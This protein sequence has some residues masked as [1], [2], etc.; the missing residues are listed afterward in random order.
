MFGILAL[1]LLMV[2]HE[3]GH[4]FA[5][6]LFGMRVLKFSIGFGPPFFQILP[7]DGYFWLTTAG[8]R[9]RLR[10][11][12]HK[13]ERQGE[14]VYQVAMIPFFAYVQIA[15]MNPLEELD[16]NDKSNFSNASLWAR[17]V[18]IFGGPLS[19]YLCASV[20]FFF[21]L[22]HGGKPGVVMVNNEPE[23]AAYVSPLPDR[24]AAKAGILA[25][26]KVVEVAGTSVGTWEQMAAQ[27]S[28]RPG[29]TIKVVVE[30]DS[31][32]TSIELVP[33]N[34]NGK[35]RIGVAPHKLRVPFGEAAVSSLTEPT[36]VVQ[37]VFLGLRELFRGKTEGLGGPLRMISETSEA[38]RQGLAEYL[39]LLGILS[40][41]IGVFNL[42]PF[43][44][45]DGGR[46]AFLGY[47]AITRRKPNAKVEIYTNV[48]GF[49]TLSGLALYVT[50]F[51][52]L[53]HM[54]S[55]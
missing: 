19:N 23:L 41:Y 17:I 15:G 30:R 6:R 54:L 45:L 55:K 52:D 35:G 31:V 21:A 28:K 14:T 47:E 3:S 11:W 4:F 48:F 37:G 10:L 20:F 34:D 44:A 22:L 39:Y 49:V 12:R 43:P 51:K 33:A 24:P 16:P 38:A 40:A 50:F 18:T 7:E 32:R 5:A 46:L 13:P 29:E 9:V 27:I 1:G 25:G 2:V 53:P 42:L 8:N 36:K 26:D